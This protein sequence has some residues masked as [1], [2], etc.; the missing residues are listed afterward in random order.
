MV[1]GSSVLLNRLMRIIVILVG[2]AGLSWFVLADVLAAGLLQ[3]WY[4]SNCT[5]VFPNFVDRNMDGWISS[6]SSTRC[7]QY[8]EGSVSPGGLDYEG[9]LHGIGFQINAA[10]TGNRTLYF[11]PYNCGSYACSGSIPV[12]QAGTYLI[13]DGSLPITVTEHFDYVVVPSTFSPG[14]M[15]FYVWGGGYKPPAATFNIDVSNIRLYDDGPLPGEEVPLVPVTAMSVELS[16]LTVDLTEAI[17][18][19]VIAEDIN[20]DPVETYTGT[21][22][23]TSTDSVAA[24]PANYTFTVGALLDN[25][26]HTFTD[27]IAFYT[28]G[29]H[30][31][32]VTDVLSPSLVATSTVMVRN[33]GPAVSLHATISP[34]TVFAGENIIQL[35]VEARDV[36]GRRAT[37]YRGSIEFVESASSTLPNICGP[38]SCGP[39]PDYTF[40]ETD[41]GIATFTFAFNEGGVQDVYVYDFYNPDM[42]TTSNHVDV[43]EVYLWAEITPSTAIAGE[44]TLTLTLSARDEYGDIWTG[45]RGQVEFIESASSTLPSL[46]GTL[47]NTPDFTFTAANAGRATFNFAFNSGGVHNV[48]IYDWVNS[49]RN[50]T[51]NNVEV[52]EI[53]LTAVISPTTAVRGDQDFV[54]TIEARDQNGNL[55]PN[56]RG[57][58]EF[59]PSAA[60]TLPDNKPPCCGDYPDYIFTAADAGSASLTFAFNETGT[61]NVYVYDHANGNRNATS[62][63]VTVTEPPP[64]TPASPGTPPP[65]YN[66]PPGLTSGGGIPYHFGLPL[67]AVSSLPS[68]SWQGYPDYKVPASEGAIYLS[69]GFSHR[70]LN[71]FSWATYYTVN[72]LGWENPLTDQRSSG[73]G[74]DGGPTAGDEYAFLVNAAGNTWPISHGPSHLGLTLSGIAPANTEGVHLDVHAGGNA[75]TSPFIIGSNNGYS[76]AS[77]NSETVSV[78]DP[79]D[80]RSG[81]FYLVER[82]LGVSTGCQ[83]ID[84]RFERVYL[85]QS[86]LSDT[87]FGYGWTHNYNQEV[88]MLTQDYVAVRRGRG[89]HLIF[90]DVGTDVYASFSGSPY[91][92]VKLPA[93]GWALVDENQYVDLFAADGKLVAQQDP[94]GNMIWLTYETASRGSE[95]VTR[96]AR[97]D[98][99]GGRYLWFGYDYYDIDLLTQVA[100]HTGR[101]V[102]YGYDEFYFLNVVTDT[103]GAATTYQYNNFL[104]TSQTDPLGNTVFTNQYD[105]GGRVITQTNSMGEFLVFDYDITSAAIT[106]TVTE[107]NIGAATRYV[108]GMDDGQLEKIIDPLG[109]VTQYRGHTETRRPTEIEDALGHVTQVAYNE[110]GWPTVVTD[111]LGNSIQVAYNNWAKPTVLTDTLGRTTQFVYDGPNLVEVIDPAGQSV[112]FIY[113]DQNGWQNM[114]AGIVNQAGLTMTLSYD[115]AGDLVALTDPLNQLTEYGYD[116]LGRLTSVTDALN[117]ITQLDY[118]DAGRLLQV[119]DPLTGTIQYEY[120]ALG[121]V[122]TMTDQVGG[123]TTIDY[124]RRFMP[125]T[126]TNAMTETV[127]MAY[128]AVGRGAR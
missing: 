54:L 42:N 44:E 25:G 101:T 114:L 90:K 32:T 86:L 48:Y 70:A 63:D 72:Y 2:V 78:G 120:D 77:C 36:E 108:Y 94:N 39:A 75:G 91:M 74:T 10:S 122:I 9:V 7:W 43:K 93:G 21:V 22:T 57:N 98:A 41:A 82:D 13:H 51:T 11:K 46:S 69:A 118:D 104:I 100:D 37:G 31:I 81:S 126:V 127:H 107:Q 1:L 99:P 27:G 105:N 79:I 67:M 96:L 128:D 125:S 52:A 30:I 115:A 92:L 106:T 60:A 61:Q 83:G 110:R 29:Q 112:Q 35:V 33:S 49:T 28:P 16:S 80:T 66:V 65:T 38:I 58:I 14:Y 121:N 8:A 109:A 84:L 95:T 73:G 62:N 117:N 47:K 3:N 113:E 5:A 26:R 50:V 56:Y 88:I 87:P 124:V 6:G 19:T 15:R 23:M 76:P 4:V 55:W 40:T 119:T 53:H 45:Y 24:L 34:T 89:D 103:M 12:N 102:Q 20:G 64:P 71:D 97:V 123:V 116:S 111:T 68:N 17:D 85:S 18:V 59:V